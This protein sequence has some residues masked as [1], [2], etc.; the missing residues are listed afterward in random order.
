MLAQETSLLTRSRSVDP[1]VPFLLT[2]E[3][4]EREFAA[5][6]LDWGAYDFIFKPLDEQAIDSVREAISLYGWRTM[7][8]DKEKVLQR[9]RRRR[10]L[11]R[12]QS[13]GTQLGHDVGRLLDMSIS[14]IEQGQDSLMKSAERIHASLEL[15]KAN[16]TTNEQE[17]RQRA[18]QRLGPISKS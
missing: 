8:A 17:A 1:Q 12:Q 16:C 14:R 2:L 13:A 18:M 10:E 15:L 4:H 3:K 5:D 11:Y 6:W 7:I 9:L